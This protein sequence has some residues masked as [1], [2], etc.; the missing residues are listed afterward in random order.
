MDAHLFRLFCQNCSPLLLGARIEKIQEPAAGHL[1]MTFYGGGSKRHLVARFGRKEPFCFLAAARPQAVASPSAAVMRIR[2]YFANRRIAAVVCQCFSRKLWLMAAQP[3]SSAKTV[4]LCLDLA[5]GPAIHFLSEEELPEV[6]NPAWPNPENLTEALQNWRLWPP[7]TPALRKTLAELEPLD[8]KALLADLATGNGDLFCYGQDK[9]LKVSA[10]PLPAPLCDGLV[11]E[12]RP[13]VLQGLQ[14]AGQDLVLLK[15]F[16]QKTRQ[17]AEPGQKRR[18]Q[19]DKILGKLGQDEV[20][21]RQMAGQEDAARLLAANLWHWDKK[22][23]LA[24]ISATDPATGSDQLVRLD[25]R[26]SL[27]E[28]MRRMFHSAARGKRGLA[29]LRERKQQLEQE[30]RQL[31]LTKPPSETGQKTAQEPPPRPLPVNLP[32]RVQSFYS[33][34]GFL[35]L[36]G[37]DAKGNLAALRHAS[38]HDI[39]VH[40]QDGPGAHVIIRRAHAGQEIPERTLLEAGTLAANK[41][42]LANAA[43]AAI[44]YAEARHIK[45]G[46]SGPVGQVIIDKLWQTRLVPVGK[47]LEKQLEAVFMGAQAY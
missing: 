11:E 3:G 46:R 6:E 22:A 33:S 38:G 21:L 34:D 39:W 16:E 37:R 12:V 28:N 2:K 29:V 42:W 27:L 7:L 1:A 44:M 24:E 45:P 36:R 41:S 4:W 5:Q 43:T 10:W 8:A 32:R 23:K 31:E 40:A 19:I 14:K 20:R 35:L 47:D 13:D 18:R 30:L 17:L 9:I 15:L 25:G 26:L